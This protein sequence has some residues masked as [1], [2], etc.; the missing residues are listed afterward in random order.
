MKTWF[1]KFRISAAFDS[2]RPLPR[3]LR[4]R[5]SNSEELRSFSG[6]VSRLE[7]VLRRPVANETP[8]GLH[9]SIMGAMRASNPDGIAACRLNWLRWIPAPA[10]AVC[11]MFAVWWFAHPHASDRGLPSLAEAFQTGEEITDDLSSQL[12]DPL[13][14]ELQRVNLDLEDT[15]RFLLATVPF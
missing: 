10:L 14:E 4:H 1:A 5:L 13:K 6:K 15:T 7:Q 12:V 11:V 3:W 9:A 8:Y 2:G